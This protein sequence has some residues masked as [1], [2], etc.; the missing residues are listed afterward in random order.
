MPGN[1]LPSSSQT[2]DSLLDIEAVAEWLGCSPRHVD[3]M[4]RA[5]RMPKPLRLGALRRWDRAV[6]K[7]WLDAGCPAPEVEVGRR[8]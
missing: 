1:A 6:V 2:T 3:R 4:A 8:A 5:G 7:K